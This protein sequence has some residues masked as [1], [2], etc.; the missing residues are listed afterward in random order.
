MTDSDELTVL[1]KRNTRNSGR[2]RFIFI[3]ESAGVGTGRT[4]ASAHDNRKRCRP[5]RFNNVSANETNERVGNLDNQS[6]SMVGI[7]V[8][9]RYSRADECLSTRF[10]AISQPDK[11]MPSRPVKYQNASDASW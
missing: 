10:L 2:G 4:I 11:P 7:G 9:S 6:V 8:D 3:N 1:R 5:A